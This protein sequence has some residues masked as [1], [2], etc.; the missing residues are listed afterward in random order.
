[1]MAEKYISV[2]DALEAIARVKKKISDEKDIEK[3]VGAGAYLLDLGAREAINAIP[4]ADVR[5][6]VYCREC[7]YSKTAK[8]NG[9][10]FL[11]CPASG[12]EITDN[13]FC[14]YAERGA[15]MRGGDADE[16]ARTL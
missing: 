16:R 10:G 1:M 14:S 15:D 2:E 6:V 5:P 4:A 9:K 11:I 3:I 7:K 8:V 13:D 12:M